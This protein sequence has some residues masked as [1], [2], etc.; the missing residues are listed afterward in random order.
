MHTRRASQAYIWYLAGS[1][2]DISA[3]FARALALEGRN[4]LGP[5]PSDTKE[6]DI[7]VGF[8]QQVQQLRMGQYRVGRSPADE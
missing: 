3:R 6:V 5:A 8:R 7:I 2:M 1:L 4:M